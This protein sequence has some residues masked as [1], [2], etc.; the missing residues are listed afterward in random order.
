MGRKLNQIQNDSRAS[1]RRR[2]ANDHVFVHSLLTKRHQWFNTDKTYRDTCRSLWNR[3]S[4]EAGRTSHMFLPSIYPNEK[5]SQ[6]TMSSYNRTNNMEEVHP[7]IANERI[8]QS[9]LNVQPVMLEIL[10]APHSS[11]VMKN[12]QTVELRKR[13]AYK[14]QAYIQKTATN[15]DRFTQLV[16]SLEEG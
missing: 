9:F 11:Q 3:Q 10:Y 8:T 4:T 1:T 7:A 14:R 15:D 6:E 16:D 2:A 12:K 5:S 13:S